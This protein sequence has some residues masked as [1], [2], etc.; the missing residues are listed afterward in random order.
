MMQMRSELDTAQSDV[1]GL[2]GGV[3]SL[4]DQVQALTKANTDLVAALKAGIV[5][6]PAVEDPSRLDRNVAPVRAASPV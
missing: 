6:V 3:S 1:T 4:T 5:N 2:K